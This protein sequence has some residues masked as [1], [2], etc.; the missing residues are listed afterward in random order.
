[1]PV[2]VRREPIRLADMVVVEG[3]IAVWALCRGLSIYGGMI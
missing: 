1:M 2:V 3:V